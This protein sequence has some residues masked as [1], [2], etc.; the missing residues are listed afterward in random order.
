[1]AS[2]PVTPSWAA[3]TR[4]PLERSRGTRALLLTGWGTF[5]LLYA[6]GA[7]MSLALAATGDLRM[8]ENLWIC[9]CGIAVSTFVVTALIPVVRSV[10]T[11]PELRLEPDA[12]VFADPVL[13][14]REV[15]VPRASV[16]RVR[17]VDWSSERLLFEDDPLAELTPLREPLNLEIRLS[18]ATAFEAARGSRT[19]NWVWHFGRP[20]KM[21]P[22]FP[23]PRGRTYDRLWLRVAD[24]ERAEADLVAWLAAAT[25]ADGG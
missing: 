25:K 17:R 1:M 22:L 18:E 5:T 4:I 23:Q 15:Q 2:V 7:A 6:G 24:P 8:P 9:L 19:G 20:W 3:S 12:L 16:E 11:R 21:R 14:R 13:F 10:L